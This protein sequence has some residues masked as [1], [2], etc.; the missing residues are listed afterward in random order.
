MHI[1][2]E[3]QQD[4]KIV[5][6]FGL[7][8]SFRDR[9]L[10]APERN[11]LCVCIVAIVAAFYS[12]TPIDAGFAG[13]FL[14]SIQ[15]VAVSRAFRGIYPWLIDGVRVGRHSNQHVVSIACVKSNTAAFETAMVGCLIA[16]IGPRASGFV[17]H[18]VIV[19]RTERLQ[20]A[21]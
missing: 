11:A 2:R 21:V 15:P 7:Y 18:D 20:V 16:A 6:W 19:A 10:L 12:T 17:L 14:S 9:Q 13:S 1:G 5:D 3:R 4:S 8:S